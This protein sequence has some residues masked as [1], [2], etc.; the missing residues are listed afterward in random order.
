MISL[1]LFVPYCGCQKCSSRHTSQAALVSLPS[2]LK[3]WHLSLY[4]R[5]GGPLLST[6]LSVAVGGVDHLPGV[7]MDPGCNQ[8]KNVRIISLIPCPFNCQSLWAFTCQWQDLPGCVCMGIL[9]PPVTHTNIITSEFKEAGQT[10]SKV[11]LLLW[12]TFRKARYEEIS[13]SSWE[14]AVQQLQGNLKT[15]RLPLQNTERS[16]EWKPLGCFTN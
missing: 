12:I 2:A 7:A 6:E 4:S 8:T 13:E 14:L 16:F 9:C 5:V 15:L 10:G 11:R 1:I 3:D